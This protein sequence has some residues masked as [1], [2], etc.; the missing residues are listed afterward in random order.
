MIFATEAKLQQLSIHKVGNKAAAEPLALSDQPYGMEDEVLNGILLQYFTGGF[1]KVQ[2]IYRLHH[3]TDNLELNEVYHFCKSIFEDPGSF[4]EN[5]RQ[6]AKQLYD[7]ADHP[8]IKPGEFYVVYF[9]N[10]QVEGALVEAIGLFKSENKETYLKVT[11]S[12][13]AFGVSYEEEAINIKKL[14]KACIIFNTEPELGYKV[15]I[16][17]N[18]NKSG[19][20][21]YWMD[22]FLKLQI[23]ND[24]YNQTHN[25]LSVYK[26]FITEKIDEKLEVSKPDKIDLLNRS[27]RYFKENEQFNLDEFSNVVLDNPVAIQ[28]WKD[29]KQHYEQESGNEIGDS[30]SI[31]NA[32][33]KKQARTY[34]SVLKLDKNFHIYIHGN[35]DLIE[36]GFDESVKMSYYKVYFNEEQ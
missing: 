19:E 22:D 7:V 34:K 32:A 17:D 13:G 8:N 28:E 2:E 9:H 36:K 6:L 33:V 21:V 35:R 5:S 23:R 15:A 26:S 11:P 30:F 3:P 10:L 18:T 27:I 1:L 25:V 4:H 31:N 29:Y 20:A 24:E 16:I 14:D 12:A